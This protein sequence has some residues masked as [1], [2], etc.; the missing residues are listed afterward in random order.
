MSGD[1]PTVVSIGSQ[2]ELGK[3]VAAATRGFYRISRDTWYRPEVV[4][5]AG[6]YGI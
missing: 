3:V 4:A 2:I 6:D 1:G 5:A